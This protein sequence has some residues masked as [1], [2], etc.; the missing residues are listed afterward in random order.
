MTFRT[1]PAEGDADFSLIAEL[2]GRVS[3]ED[4]T[5]VEEIRWA[6]AT[7]PGTMRLLAESDGRSIGFGTAGRMYVHPPDFDAFWA[8][9]GVVPESRRRG[10]GT[11]LLIAVSEHARVAGKV[12]LHLPASDARPE[13]I[14]F[15]THRG[16]LEYE[17]SK[18]VELRLAGC[19]IPDIE[20][21]TGIRITTLAT[22]PDLISGVHDVA[23][24][25]YEDIPGGD[26]PIA[27]GDLAEFRTRDVD[28]PGIPAD[29]F[30][31]ALDDRTGR[32]AGFASLLLMAG[33]RERAWHANTAVARV[34]VGVAWRAP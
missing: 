5:S 17:R 19:P 3:P 34:C 18:T 11:A 6:A 31:I 8:T 22:R 33:G 4:P 26:E 2:V 29:G 20:P 23:V 30:M 7:F 25:A 10:I 13:G 14:A 21:P 32:V 15:L 16:F 28:R 27:A 12:A 9:I 1:R 24:Q